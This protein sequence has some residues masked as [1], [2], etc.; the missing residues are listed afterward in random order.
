MCCIEPTALARMQPRSQII[1]WVNRLVPAPSLP[2]RLAA[3][4]LAVVEEQF[5]HR[6]GADPHLFQLFAD[7]QA[8]RILL[9]EERR[10]ALGALRFVD[11]GVDDAEIGDRPVGDPGLVAVEDVVVAV[12]GG[13]GAQ[14]VGVGAGSGLAGRVGADEAAVDSPGQEFLLLLLGA[15]ADQRH[16]HRPHVGVEREDEAVVAA[17]VAE[18][19]ERADRRQRIEPEPT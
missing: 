1:A 2:S 7:A 9:D 17:G 16:H 8:G 19:V 12:E 11:G 13:G 15:E 6:R 18:A 3:G 14:A 10:H 4:I 5:G